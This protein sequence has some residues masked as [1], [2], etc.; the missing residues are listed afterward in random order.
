MTTHRI[1]AEATMAWDAGHRRRR[2]S[3]GLERG[4]DGVMATGG[5]LIVNAVAGLNLGLPAGRAG[6][7]LGGAL[8]AAGMAHLTH[9]RRRVTRA[10]AAAPSYAAYPGAH[11]QPARAGHRA[12]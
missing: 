3:A 1:A 11:L 7:S 9:R 12:A 5:M 8:L 2:A 6:M 10:R 4:V